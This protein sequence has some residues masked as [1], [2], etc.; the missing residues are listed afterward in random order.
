MIIENLHQPFEIVV[1]RLQKY[2]VEERVFSFFQLVYVVYGKG[3]ECINDNRVDYEAGNLFLITPEDCHTFEIEEETKFIFISFNKSYL[4]DEHL[5][6]ENK[7]RLEIILKN[8]NH[9][10]G[11]ILSHLPDKPLVKAIMEAMIDDTDDR[12]LYNKELVIQLVNTLIII[13]ARNVLRLMPDEAVT[14]EDSKAVEIIH[15]I[16]TNIYYPEKLRTSALSALFN[17]SESYLGKYFKKHTQENLQTFINN[18][19][20]KMI[21]SR[22]RYSD[23][24]CSEVAYE[25]G[26]T[27]ESHF[28]KFFRQRRGMSPKEFRKQTNRFI[29]TV[30]RQE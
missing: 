19:R 4:T 1:E 17:I 21:E 27:D 22:L 15:Y 9:K 12:E 8:A 18:Y 25:F 29:S 24:R 16:Q 7:R 14:T 11:C 20:M 2:P 6:R 28:N 5:D 23:M 30:N 13:T 26:F 10:S 3:K